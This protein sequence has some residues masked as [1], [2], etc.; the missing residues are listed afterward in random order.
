[1]VSMTV[2]PDDSVV[3]GHG[4]QVIH[5]CTKSR[6][7][8]VRAA[9][10]R[11]LTGGSL[12]STHPLNAAARVRLSAVPGGTHLLL[13]LK[14]GARLELGHAPSS[15]IAMVTARLIA[16]LTRCSI[17]VGEGESEPQRAKVLELPPTER[18]IAPPNFEEAPTPIDVP[19]VVAPLRAPSMPAANGPNAAGPRP[20]GESVARPAEPVFLQ[21]LLESSMESAESPLPG[22]PSGS[23]ERR[24]AIHELIN[25]ASERLPIADDEDPPGP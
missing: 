21:L 5:F 8:H 15:E 18:A 3:I 12:L 22:A 17:E 10:S 19:K 9:S 2:L 20:R 11:S 14:T 25:L 23:T 1:M 16:E 4:A 13:E 6:G 24:A 7:I